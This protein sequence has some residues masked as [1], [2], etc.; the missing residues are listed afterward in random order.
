MG[1]GRGFGVAEGDAGGG[2]EDAADGPGGFIRRVFSWEEDFAGS[3]LLRA[4]VPAAEE[5]EVV[6]ECGEVEG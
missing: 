5:R 3:L 2:V 6:G 1:F 4:I